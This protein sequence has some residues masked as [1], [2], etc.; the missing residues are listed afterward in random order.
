MSL[1]ITLKMIPKWCQIYIFYIEIAN[2]H[3]SCV[4][5][6]LSFRTGMC[7]LISLM[8]CG[9]FTQILSEIKAWWIGERITN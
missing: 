9:V 3:Y 6:A 1:G 5:F 8:L 7:F 4:S 2:E